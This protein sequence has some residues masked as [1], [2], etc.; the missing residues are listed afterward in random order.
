MKSARG[1]VPTP[2]RWGLYTAGREFRVAEETLASK[3]NEASEHPGE[4][5]CYTTAQITKVLWD[6]LLAEKFKKLKAETAKVELEN[7]ILRG[8]Y[9]AKAELQNRLGQIADGILQIIKASGLAK[10][11]QDDLQWQIASIPVVVKDAAK[12][13]GFLNGQSTE[14]KKRG[15]PRKNPA[16]ETEG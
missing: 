15:R 2:T 10:E 7:A 14:K 3:L 13:R 5:G 9:V 4:D 11:A 8:E 6:S 12:G 16:P 1:N